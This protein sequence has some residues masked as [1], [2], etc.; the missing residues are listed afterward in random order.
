MKAVIL[1]IRRFTMIVLTTDAEFKKIP[2]IPGAK[3]GQVI[4]I[5]SPPLLRISVIAVI[6]LGIISGTFH[7][8]I[9]LIS[10]ILSLEPIP[11]RIML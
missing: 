4:M 11:V 5:S 1:E 8:P 7:I 10:F 3:V 2:R 6:V 9:K